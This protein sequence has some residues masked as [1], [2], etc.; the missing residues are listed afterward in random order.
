MLS[1]LQYYPSKQNALHAVK[2]WCKVRS[3]IHS[4]RQ[5]KNL[6]VVYTD[7]ELGEGNWLSGTHRVAASEIRYKLGDTQAPYED[8]LIVDISEWLE[9][10]LDAEE[11]DALWSWHNQDSE[12]V[13]GL[14]DL[15]ENFPE[16]LLLALRLRLGYPDGKKEEI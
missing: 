13:C 14:F 4:L 12:D 16:K 1:N 8:L 3:M 9:P 11:W 15:D 7:G 5:G 2:D 6:P 10:Y